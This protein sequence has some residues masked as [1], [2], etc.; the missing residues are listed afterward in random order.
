[1]RNFMVWSGILLAMAG[2]AC[3]KEP[4]PP[5]QEKAPQEVAAN[6][7][8]KGPPKELTVDLGGGVKLEMVLIPAGEF[9]MGSPDSDKD[10]NADEKPQHRV[11]ITKPF[12]LGKYLVTQEQWE[13][14]MGSNPSRFKGPKNPV[15][16]VT[17]YPGCQ[18]F[19]DKLN[20][21]ALGQPGKFVL[22]T[23][24]QWEYACRAGSATCYCFGDKES[25]LDKYAW[26]TRNSDI[27]THPVGQ[28]K[29]NA[30]GLYDMQGNVEQW[31]RDWYDPDY[32]TKSPV[33]DPTGPAASRRRSRVERGGSII[34]P[35]WVCRPAARGGS[36]P[37]I[38]TDTSGFRV[39]LVPAE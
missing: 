21:R 22:P 26:Y 9:L 2:T 19:L 36:T 31:C 27:G 4:Q 34:S 28:K 5:E 37:W 6:S 33:T 35:G 17:W 32:F 11:R 25:E 15:E 10:A 13:A 38:T 12:Y 7:V 24:A 14:V 20:A 3:N 18:A 29:P 23:E 8:T 16:Q 30:W 1:M 39:S